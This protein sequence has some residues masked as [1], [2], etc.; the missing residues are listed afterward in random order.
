MK[1]SRISNCSECS[2]RTVLKGLG[3][4]AAVALVPGCTQG[5]NLPTGKTT[6]CGT[7]VCLDLNDS[8]NKALAT[9]GGALLVDTNRDTIMVIRM[10]STDVI[11]L[12]AICTH[13]G[14]S[15]NFNNSSQLL[16]CPC[17]GS[18]FAENGQVVTGPAFRP[19]TTYAASLDAAT[20]TITIIL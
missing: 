7:N 8:S 17:H 2:R 11:A 13:A 14:C 10:S 9:P 4:A 1:V 5:S 20:H 16:E 12:S 15:M 6:S 3:V 19:L 18:R